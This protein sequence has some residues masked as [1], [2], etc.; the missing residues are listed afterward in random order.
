[1]S[2]PCIEYPGCA[3]ARVR[4]FACEGSGTYSGAVQTIMHLYVQNYQATF[5]E[6]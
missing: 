2:R 1:M 3:G 4:G 6:D 5:D